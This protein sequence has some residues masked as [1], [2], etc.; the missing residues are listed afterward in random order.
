MKVI[1]QE[2]DNPNGIGEFEILDREQIEL[3]S[4]HTEDFLETSDKDFRLPDSVEDSFEDDDRKKK[5]KYKS[6]D[7]NHGP[8]KF[9]SNHSSHNNHYQQSGVPTPFNMGYPPSKHPSYHSQGIVKI[10]YYNSDHSS[11]YSDHYNK[12]LKYCTYRYTYLWLRNGRS[13]WCY[14]TYVSHNTLSGWKWK[15]Y[16]WKFFSIPIK[17]ISNFYCYR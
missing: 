12:K 7:K 4:Q 13:F 8:Y 17:R 3:L 1:Y 9:P 15:N 11:H 16:K 6:I 2:K 5:K 14:P 10:P